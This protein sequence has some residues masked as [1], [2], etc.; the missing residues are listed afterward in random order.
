MCNGWKWRGACLA[1]N[2]ISNIPLL[3]RPE[4]LAHI[5]AYFLAFTPP[6]RKKKVNTLKPKS[7]SFRLGS[8]AA[9]LLS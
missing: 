1:I 5:P 9:E 4:T 8:F 2:A 6:P 7:F 3:N